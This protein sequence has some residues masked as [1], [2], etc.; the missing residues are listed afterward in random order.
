MTESTRMATKNRTAPATKP[1][2]IK[3]GSAAAS[4]APSPK[5]FRMSLVDCRIQYL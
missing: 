1:N 2:T 4:A 5:P 3:T